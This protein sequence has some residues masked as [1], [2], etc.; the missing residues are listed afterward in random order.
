MNS[1]PMDVDIVSADTMN[2]GLLMHCMQWRSW[3]IVGVQYQDNI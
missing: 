2:G 1:C 3:Q